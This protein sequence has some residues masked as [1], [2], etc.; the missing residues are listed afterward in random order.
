MEQRE[1]EIRELALKIFQRR[2]DFNFR[3][4]PDPAVIDKLV[5]SEPFQY[6]IEE[7]TKQYDKRTK[8]LEVNKNYPVVEIASDGKSGMAGGAYVL[9]FVYSKFKG[10][11]VVKGYMREVEDYIKK[12]FTHYFVNYTLWYMGSH[13]DIWKFWKKDIGIHEPTR[14]IKR[15]NIPKKDRMFRVRPYVSWDYD[16]SPEEREK[17]HK[18]ADEKQ[19][20]FKRMPKRWIPEFD[21]L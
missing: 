3:A 2:L 13:R 18:E 9:A 6:Y 19:L 5:E 7:A 1:Q 11:V 16:L 4:N 21:T 8:A 20:V 15:K 17:Q 14:R 10:N 12:N